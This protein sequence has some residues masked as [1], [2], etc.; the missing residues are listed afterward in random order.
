MQEL[1]ISTEKYTPSKSIGYQVLLGTEGTPKNRIMLAVAKPYQG[2]ST[3]FFSEAANQN[4]LGNDVEL[5]ETENGLDAHYM[6][7]FFSH[8]EPEGGHT[9]DY[10]LNFYQKLLTQKAKELDKRTAPAK[11]KNKMTLAF[12]KNC[13]ETEEQAYEESGSDSAAK[14]MET[15]EKLIN[16]IKTQERV[17]QLQ[18][19]IATNEYPYPKGTIILAGKGR[20]TQQEAKKILRD[21]RAQFRLQDVKITQDIRSF[22]KMEAYFEEHILKPR[23]DDWGKARKHLL[24]IID[25]LTG[26]FPEKD[27]DKE[28]SSEGNHFGTAKYLH[29]WIPKIYQDLKR[30][31]ITLAITC[32][33][34]DKIKMSVF[35]RSDEI[36]DAVFRGGNQLKFAASLIFLIDRVDKGTD[37]LDGTKCPAAKIKCIKAKQRG[38][39]KDVALKAEYHI[40]TDENNNTTLD[41]DEPFY[42]DWVKTAHDTDPEAG[43]FQANGKIHLLT[44]AAR[45]SKQWHEDWLKKEKPLEDYTNPPKSIMDIYG[46]EAPFIQE[47]QKNIAT[48]LNNE[49]V[50]QTIRDTR[51]ISLEVSRQGDVEE[52][53]QN[54]APEPEPEEESDKKGKKGKK[55]EE[56]SEQEETKESSEAAADV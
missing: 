6:A 2:K 15:M 7:S 13:L 43:V 53:H 17:A 35:D 32:Q 5:I 4:R 31:N 49:H 29:Q 9:D 40:L 24:V 22:E 41:F 3:L 38:G 51:E 10:L 20:I 18:K 42:R 28:S 45:Y 47:Y 21:A 23:R 37:R 46:G 36:A 34:N 11:K 52:T 19:L 27:L 12:A 16:I 54:K 8:A 26:L 25:S 48:L 30:C 56:T 39:A 14:N 50:R 44:Q 55:S 1:I 33:L